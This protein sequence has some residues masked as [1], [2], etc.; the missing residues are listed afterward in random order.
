[1]SPTTTWLRLSLL[2]LPVTCRT[3]RTTRATE[4]EKLE[5]KN[6]VYRLRN[7]P[8]RYQFGQQVYTLAT[9]ARDWKTNIFNFYQKKAFLEAKMFVLIIILV[10]HSISTYVDRRDLLQ[11]E[12]LTALPWTTWILSLRVKTIMILN[13]IMGITKVQLTSLKEY[14]IFKGVQ[15]TPF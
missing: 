6:N 9:P 14:L 1:M 11:S 15:M 3:C 8:A 2:I 4:D 7:Q 5:K 10:N 13:I 12:L